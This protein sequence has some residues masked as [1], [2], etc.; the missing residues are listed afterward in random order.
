MANSPPSEVRPLYTSRWPPLLACHE[1]TNSIDTGLNRMHSVACGPNP[2]STS[3]N[4]ELFHCRNDF[5]GQQVKRLW[6]GHVG[7]THDNLIDAQL[8]Q[9]RKGLDGCRWGKRTVMPIMGKL[10][11][12]AVDRFLNL[13]IGASHLHTVLTQ[14]R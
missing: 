12:V 9:S 6:F 3:S 7:Q 10:K 14:H 1:F 5:C 2:D 13:I 4:R 11:L 8:R